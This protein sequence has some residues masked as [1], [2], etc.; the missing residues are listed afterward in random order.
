MSQKKLRVGVVGLGIGR[1][2]V[3]CFL[4]DERVQLAAVGENALKLR[5]DGQLTEAFAAS[6]GAKLYP[7]A[8]A[9]IESGDIDAVSL[10]VTPKHRMVLL[11]AAARRGLP[12]LMEKPMAATWED[13]LAMA[14]IVRRAG[15]LFM[16]EYPMRY[17]P[18]TRSCRRAGTLRQATG[19]GMR[20][21]ATAS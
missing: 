19:R 12:V 8:V 11:E 7:D 6:V 10:A 9:M 3:E 14:R 20:R 1:G 18:S 4:Q 2:H 13:S 5:R 15:I 16:M 21:T 17:C